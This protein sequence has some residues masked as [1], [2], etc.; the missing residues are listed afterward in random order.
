MAH[1]ASRVFPAYTGYLNTAIVVSCYLCYSPLMK[2]EHGAILA[3]RDNEIAASRRYTTYYKTLTFVFSA[4]LAGIAGGLYAQAAS[5]LWPAS[6]A[7]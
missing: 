4:F 7:L 6:L 5:A 2:S 1:Q 3:I